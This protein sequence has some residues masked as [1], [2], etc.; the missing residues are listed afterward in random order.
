MGELGYESRFMA[1]TMGSVYLIMLATIVG[2]I[3]L[4]VFGALRYA[5]H[6]A[7]APHNK[8]KEW[9][10]WNYVLRL[11]LSNCLEIFMTLFMLWTF[12]DQLF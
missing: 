4:L 3:L 10:L 5:C 12:T 11:L 7:R 2:F 1:R 9:L 8:L 6:C